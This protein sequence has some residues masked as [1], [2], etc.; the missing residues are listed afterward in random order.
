MQRRSGMDGGSLNGTNF[1]AIATIM[2]ALLAGVTTPLLNTTTAPIAELEWTV[3][4]MQ[5]INER[6]A[7]LLECR[8]ELDKGMLATGSVDYAFWL[9][10]PKLLWWLCKAVL[11][12]IEK[13]IKNDKSFGR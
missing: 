1:S 2:C 8:R 4:T 3:M 9:D 12:L 6:R 10:I 7:K 5:P 13:E 11:L